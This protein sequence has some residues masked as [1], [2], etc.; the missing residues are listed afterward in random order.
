MSTVPHRFPREREQED[1]E[2]TREEKE[3]NDD[4]ENWRVATRMN[5]VVAVLVQKL[6]SR[7]Y[8]STTHFINAKRGQRRWPA[9]ETSRVPIFGSVAHRI[10]DII[11]GVATPSGLS[12]TSAAHQFTTHPHG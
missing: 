6:P 9:L 3:E 4:D 5:R 8:V 11:S 12:R 7:A 2:K 1:E 10:A